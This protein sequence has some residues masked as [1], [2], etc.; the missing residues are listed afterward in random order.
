MQDRALAEIHRVL[1]PGG[2]LR[3]VTDHADLWAWY[4]DHARR[5]RH[6]F[7]RRPFRAGESDR[8]G[9]LVGTNY[10]RKFAREGR[11][12]F[13]MTLKKTSTDA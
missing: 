11:A 8:S 1:V 3:L 6:R 12:F 9:E 10:E 4:E 13:A 7:E 2:E 5:H